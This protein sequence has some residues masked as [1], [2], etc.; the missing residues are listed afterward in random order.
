M[1]NFKIENRI[2]DRFNKPLVIPEIGINHEGSL[3]KAIELVDSVIEAGG[4]IVKFQCHITEKEMLNTGIKPPNSCLPLWDIMKQCEL[5]KDEEKYLF[6]YVKQKGLIYLSTPFSRE[7]VDRLED[8]GVSAYKIGSGECNNIPLIRH[9]ASTGKPIILS[10]GMNDLESIRASVE[11]IGR[12]NVPLAILHCTS[13]YPTPYKDVRLNCIT[14]LCEA[15]PESIVGLSDHSIGIWTSLG[16]IS[17]GALIIEKHFTVSKDW[18]GPDIEISIDTNELRQLITGANAIWESLG[19]TKGILED[20][21]PVIDFA[22]ASVVS[23][24]DIKAGDVLSDKNIWVKRPGNGPFQAADYEK[25]LGKRVK[26]NIKSD[27]FISPEMLET[28]G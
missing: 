22:Y 14:E 9:I 23:I 7:A 20:E 12:H 17:L 21:K 26:N 1:N 2:I 5:S 4:E 10:T 18:P 16:A 15:F 27:M 25:L 3:E 28:H 6:N 11:E 8:F 19:G 24:A 13:L